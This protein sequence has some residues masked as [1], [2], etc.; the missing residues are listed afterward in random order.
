LDA[1]AESEIVITSLMD[2]RSVL[3]VTTSSEGLLRG[4]RPGT[5]HACLTTI[6]PACADQLEKLHAD[7][8]TA[9]IS[10]PVVGRPNAAAAGQLASFLAGNSDAISRFEPVCRTYSTLVTKVSDR[11]RLANVMKLVINYN[12]ACTIELV[13]ES[14][15]FAEKCGLPLE[16]VRDFYRQLWFAH[17]A[18]KLYANKLLE[19]DFKGRGGFVMTGGLKDVKL[20]L[21]AA[22]EAGAN[23]KVGEIVERMLSEGI[24]AGMGEQDWSSFHEIARQKAGLD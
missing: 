17:P 1:A 10:A 2:D 12:V 8:G 4:M 19:R 5:T 13:S 14:Y 3:D 24:A 18:A 11:P 23:L 21:S 20:M 6:S 22:A 7:V 16:Y 15:I 9:Y